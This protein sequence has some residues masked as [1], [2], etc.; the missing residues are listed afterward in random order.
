M[1]KS[2]PTEE[3]SIGFLKQVEAGMPIRKLCR[4]AGSGDW[5]F[6]GGRA[7]LGGVHVSEAQRLL[8]EALMNILALPTIKFATLN[9]S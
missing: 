2:R 3:Q 1:K 6:Y 4:T 7:K 8:P 9:F 5:R